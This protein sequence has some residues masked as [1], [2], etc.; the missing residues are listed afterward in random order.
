MDG[1][2]GVGWER[3]RV[4][5]ADGEGWGEREREGCMGERGGVGWERNG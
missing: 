1:R 4:V 2:G 3:E 5:W